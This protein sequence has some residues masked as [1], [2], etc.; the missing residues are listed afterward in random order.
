MS[1]TFHYIHT[2]AFAV[3]G[4]EAVVRG[5]VEAM[6]LMELERPTMCFRVAQDSFFLFF[7]VE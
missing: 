6:A 7:F 5:L 1:P 2:L 4:H 3:Q